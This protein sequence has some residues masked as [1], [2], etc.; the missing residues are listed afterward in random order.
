MR[1][2]KFIYLPPL[3][4][5]RVFKKNGAAEE[6]TDGLSKFLGCWRPVQEAVLRPG[7]L[8]LGQCVGLQVAPFFTGLQLS[9][10]LKSSDIVNWL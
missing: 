9:S 10:L 3:V 4:L 7:K 8:L 1:H 2:V 6:V 5:S